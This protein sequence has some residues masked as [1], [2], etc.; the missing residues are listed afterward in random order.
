MI[1]DVISEILSWFIPDVAEYVSKR[2]RG[3]RAERAKQTAPPPEQ[4]KRGKRRAQRQARA[5]NRLSR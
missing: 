4:T 1:R 5:R 2:I 3:D